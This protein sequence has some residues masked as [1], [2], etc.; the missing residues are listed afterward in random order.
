MQLVLFPGIRVGVGK[1]NVGG[2]GIHFYLCADKC[3]LSVQ[4]WNLA[5]LSHISP[6][7]V[8]RDANT[9]ERETKFEKFGTFSRVKFKYLCSVT[10]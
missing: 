5:S 3:F 7:T 6:M 4:C 10:F 2:E 1:G 9:P 8:S